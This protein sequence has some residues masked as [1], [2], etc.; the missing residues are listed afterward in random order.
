MPPSVFCQS[1]NNCLLSNRYSHAPVNVTTNTTAIP[2]TI[3]GHDPPVF[4]GCHSQDLSTGASNP[5]M[6]RLSWLVKL[7][8]NCTYVRM[9]PASIT[10]NYSQCPCEMGTPQ[11]KNPGPH[12]PIVIWGPGV[13]RTLVIWGSLS[14]LGTQGL[15]SIYAIREDM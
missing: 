12:I 2:C 8:K 4:S 5:S 14:D 9:Q 3:G 10:L 7:Y 6:P 15:C 11:F 1:I 13:T